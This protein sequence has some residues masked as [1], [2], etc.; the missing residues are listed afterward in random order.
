MFPVYKE[1]TQTPN[2]KKVVAERHVLGAMAIQVSEMETKSK[3]L[4]LV[5]GSV[6][7]TNNMRYVSS[8]FSKKTV[9]K[10]SLST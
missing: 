2:A 5:Q 10:L 6:R 8:F 3:I 4:V 7:I 9:G 1:N